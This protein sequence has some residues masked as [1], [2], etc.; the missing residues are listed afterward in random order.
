MTCNKQRAPAKVQAASATLVRL[1]NE[2]VEPKTKLVFCSASVSFGVSLGQ[3][4]LNCLT[5]DSQSSFLFSAGENPHEAGMGGRWTGTAGGRS[6]TYLL[7]IFLG[8]ASFSE[9]SKTL[10]LGSQ[11]LNE[12]L[13]AYN[14]VHRCLSVHIVSFSFRQK[15][16]LH[17]D[18]LC[19]EICPQYSHAHIC[20][21]WLTCTHWEHLHAFNQELRRISLSF[22]FFYSS[23]SSFMRD[24][25]SRAILYA[26]GL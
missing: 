11:T 4:G 26:C 25:H 16:A 24:L 1:S 8:L 13:H 9:Y 18:S 21:C 5:G 12:A 17:S 23:F 7:C 6:G 10:V 15:L 19:I 20:C 3:R 2:S 14:Q 22:I